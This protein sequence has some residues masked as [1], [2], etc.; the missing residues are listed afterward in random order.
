MLTNNRVN[1]LNRNGGQG[2]NI[3]LTQDFHPVNTAHRTNLS[4]L[5]GQIYG[6]RCDILGI[7]LKTEIRVQG[8]IGKIDRPNSER[9]GDA[10]V[11]R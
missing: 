6:C 8:V 2:T 4:V 3:G 7:E 9:A 1:E 11:T 10:S 5:S